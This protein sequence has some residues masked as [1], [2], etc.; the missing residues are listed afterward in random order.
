[1]F[2]LSDLAQF[3]GTEKYHRSS[4]FFKDIVHTDG[5][6]FVAEHGGAWMVDVIT[7]YQ[8]YKKFKAEEFQFWKFK[9]HED[10]SCEAIC[11]DGNNNELVNQKILYTDLTFDVEFYLQ[12]G[13][14]DLKNPMWVIMLP[15]EY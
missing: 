12:L 15:G 1:M 6:Q 5:V 8:G 13:S 14:I 4:A 11:T 2:T 3:S 7:S 10:K 9:V